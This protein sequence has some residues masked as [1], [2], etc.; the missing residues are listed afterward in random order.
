MVQWEKPRKFPQANR[1]MFREMKNSHA[2]CH[3]IEKPFADFEHCV[4]GHI[5]CFDC[6]F[7]DPL[8]ASRVHL[9]HGSMISNYLS[10]AHISQF[11]DNFLI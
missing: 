9:L 2:N 4:N 3:A 6:E 1:E 11:T 8:R 5:N 7:L 10:L